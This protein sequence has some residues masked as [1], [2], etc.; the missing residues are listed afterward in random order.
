MKSLNSLCEIIQVWCTSSN[1]GPEGVNVFIKGELYI[2]LIT[3]N[4]D[5]T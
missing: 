1:K 3:Q 2:V 4:F 5:P